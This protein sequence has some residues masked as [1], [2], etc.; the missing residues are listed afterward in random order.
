MMELKSATL[1]R[2]I[3]VKLKETIRTLIEQNG[4]KLHLKQKQIIKIYTKN[5]Y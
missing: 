5:C 2:T 1:Q 3:R 4:T